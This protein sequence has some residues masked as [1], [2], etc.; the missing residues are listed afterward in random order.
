MYTYDLRASGFLFSASFRFWPRLKLALLFVAILFVMIWCWEIVASRPWT[1]PGQHQLLVLDEQVAD[2][3][4]P[5]GAGRN[6]KTGVLTY[7]L[8]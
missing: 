4:F 1:F 8:T 7:Y 6:P 5:G 3:W 2:P